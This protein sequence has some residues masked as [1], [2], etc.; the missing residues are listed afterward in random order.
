MAR[1]K[2]D[3]GAPHEVTTSEMPRVSEE[4]TQILFVVDQVAF[5]KRHSKAGKY[6]RADANREHSF[7]LLG[8]MAAALVVLAFIGAAS[9]AGFNNSDG[10]TP[11]QAG[12]ETGMQ[13]APPPESV[14]DTPDGSEQ[15]SP[16]A[17]AQPP[18]EAAPAPE[19]ITRWF[20]EAN[21]EGFHWIAAQITARGTPVSAAQLF[22]AN[23]HLDGVGPN[24][25][26][27]QAGIWLVVDS[28]NT[29]TSLPAF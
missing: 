9:Y 1:H 5:K 14:P 18:A 6:R 20:V 4:P 7:V 22:D 17:P 28:T 3:P 13:A 8:R 26:Y 2:F 15:Q 29:A 27:V 23:Q 12:V 16:D 11:N 10:A 24:T 21:G 25:D 19:K